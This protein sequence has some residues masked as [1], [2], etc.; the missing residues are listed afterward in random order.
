MVLASGLPGSSS[1]SECCVMAVRA[2]RILV[3]EDHAV[4]RRVLAMCLELLGHEGTFAVDVGSALVVAA[5]ADFDVL[6]TDVGLP[7][8][9][10][11]ALVEELVARGRLPA[12]AISMS[13]APS[14]QARARSEAVGC[15]AHLLKPFTIEA[16]EA[17]LGSG[18]D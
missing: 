6:L 16:L 4:I 3:V 7:G 5:G 15:Q 8:R 9:D 11:W 18:G 1:V 14:A 10:G 12:V 13:A 2:L 17:A